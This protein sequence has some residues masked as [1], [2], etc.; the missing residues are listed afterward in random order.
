MQSSSCQPR[1]YCEFYTEC[2]GCDHANTT[3]CDQL[4]CSILR[5]YRMTKKLDEIEHRIDML[6]TS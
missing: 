6:Q 5:M 1:N 4:T 3:E 2:N